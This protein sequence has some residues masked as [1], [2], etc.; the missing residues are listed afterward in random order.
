MVPSLSAGYL[1]YFMNVFKMDSIAIANLEIISSLFLLL[2][3]LTYSY[4]LIKK[5]PRTVF[6]TTNLFSVI[7][8][9]FFVFIFL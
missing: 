2:G 4:Y 8:C 6:I 1:F 9:F 5:K 3:L 7:V